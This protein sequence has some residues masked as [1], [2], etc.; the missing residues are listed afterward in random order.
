[1]NYEMMVGLQVKDEKVYSDYRNAMKPLL[2]NAGGGFRYDFKVSEVLKNEEGRPINRV[3][4]IYFP[5]KEKSDT[6]FSHPEYLEI[7]RKF[8]ES[9][10]EATTIISSYERD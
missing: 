4:A 6:F 9:S 10:V 1:M 5:S 8:F 7:K 2:E 3:F